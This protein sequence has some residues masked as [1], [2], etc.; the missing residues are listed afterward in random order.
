MMTLAS[1]TQRKSKIIQ[2]GFYQD[3]RLFW[4]QVRKRN[5]TAAHMMDNW[6]R[7]ANKMAQ[8]FKE[9]GHPIFTATSALI[10]GMLKQRQ[11][12]CT[13]HFNGDFS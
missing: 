13:V 5:G 10:R 4:V 2:R 6:D 7:T 8:Q 12:K 3:I 9:T 11:G 1:R